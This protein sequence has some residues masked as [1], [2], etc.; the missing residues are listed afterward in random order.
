MANYIIIGGDQKEYGPITGND[1]RKWIAE[2]RLNEQSLMKAESDAE[3][4]QLSAF[5]EFADAF[6]TTTPIPDIAPLLGV[7]QD[8]RKAALEK[9]KAPAVG[10]MVSAIISFIMSVWGLI[11][12]G[13]L[14]AQKQQMDTMLSQLNNPQLQ[15]FA[16]SFMHFLSG[17]FGVANILFQILIAV[18]IFMGALQMLKLRSYEFAF[19]AAILSVLP[20]IT[21]C[22][23]WLLGLVFGFWAMV[24]LG[25][26]K[27][28]FS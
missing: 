14:A 28:H 27:P 10:L 19:A 3:W 17:P 18:L 24:V 12:F 23:G 4:R 5:P 16:D 25:K 11:S 21:P 6:G 9:V 2:G 26:V 1:V 20:C 8:E 22:C 7:G 13:S 15:Q